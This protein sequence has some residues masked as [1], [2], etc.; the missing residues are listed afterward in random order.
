MHQNRD[1]TVR[2]TKPNSLNRP[3]EARGSYVV[4]VRDLDPIDVGAGVGEQPT[5]HLKRV[6]ASVVLARPRRGVLVVEVARGLRS[7][8]VLVVDPDRLE[9][10]VVLK[11]AELAREAHPFESVAFGRVQLRK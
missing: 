8:V 3:N 7:R 6:G 1:K 9:V 2:R 5:L 11:V 10:D 4:R